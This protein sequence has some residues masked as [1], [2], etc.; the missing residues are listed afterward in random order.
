VVTFRNGLYAALAAGAAIIAGVVLYGPVLYGI[1]DGHVHAAAPPAVLNRLKL[2]SGAPEIADVSF[3]D[4]AGKTVHLADFKGR[5]VLLNLWATWCG[6][7][8]NE[9]PALSALQA[10]IPKDRLT[11]VPVD[12]ERLDAAKVKDFL[13]QH[14]AGGL[15]VYIDREMATMRGFAANELPLTVLIDAQGHEL[16]RAAGG[17]KWDDPASVAY[18]KALAMPKQGS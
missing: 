17:Q 7:C 4:A 14:K 5:Y 3:A 18:F 2:S 12:L 10:D 1:T 13:G 16:A 6:P 15:P 9:L 8:I 11:V